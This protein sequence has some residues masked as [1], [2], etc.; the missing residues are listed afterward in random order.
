MNDDKPEKGDFVFF[1][2]PYLVKDVK[3]YYKD[4][5]KMKD[6]KEL[7]N[8]CDKLD[9][10]NVNFMVTLNCTKEFKEL[11]KNYN[12]KCINKKSTTSNKKGGY[13]EK[14]MVITNY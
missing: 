5:F 12:I 6:F 4:V 3:Q 10:R 1:D 14:E 8:I 9:K 2:P 7:K 13:I 11:F